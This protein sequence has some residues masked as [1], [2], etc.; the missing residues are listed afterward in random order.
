MESYKDKNR[1]LD[2]HVSGYLK[3][4]KKNGFKRPFHKLQ[5]VS[6]V[7]MC[8]LFSIFSFM[9]L[10]L[11]SNT[12]KLAIG[13]VY[14]TSLLFVITTGFLCTHIDP[15]DPAIAEATRSVLLS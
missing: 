2:F 4:M 13:I 8:Y 14:G 6:W 5:I 10:S 3:S 12:Q 11:F 7:C 15:T 9:T 1:V